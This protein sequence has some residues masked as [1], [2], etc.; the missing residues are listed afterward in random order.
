MRAACLLVV[1][2]G[3]E[4]PGPLVSG[5]SLG[6]CCSGPWF[7]FSWVQIICLY[8]CGRFTLLEETAAPGTHPVRARAFWAPEASWMCWGW[9]VLCGPGGALTEDGVWGR[10]GGRRPQLQGALAGGHVWLLRG[11]PSGVCVIRNP[12]PATP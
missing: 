4:P 11:G 3:A 10:Q 7:A 1:P 8:S 12:V 2:P 9:G 5:R 6:S